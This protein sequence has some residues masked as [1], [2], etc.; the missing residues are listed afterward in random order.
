VPLTTPLYSGAF[1]TELEALYNDWTRLI[2]ELRQIRGRIASLEIGI[3]A[4]A[5]TGQIREYINDPNI[6]GP[7]GT[8]LLPTLVNAGALA[9]KKGGGV[10]LQWDTTGHTWIV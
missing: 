1:T 4:L 6:E 8:P 3:T 10:M 7:G 2:E 9:V 5:Q